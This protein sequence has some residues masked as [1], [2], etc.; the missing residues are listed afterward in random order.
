M[1]SV[2]RWCCGL[3]LL[4]LNMSLACAESEPP[5]PPVLEL[6][7]PSL[8]F[9][10]KVPRT[11]AETDRIQ[12]LALF[13]E[14]R[15]LAQ[16]NENE[17]ALRKFQRAFRYDQTSVTTLR[18]LLP[19]AFTLNRNSEAV[20]Y[21]AKFASLD[22]SDPTLLLRLAVV[23]TEQGEWKKALALYEKAI[24]AEKPDTKTAAGIMLRMEMGR[25]Y[26]LNDEPSKATASFAQVLAALSAPK[27]YQLSDRQ[28]NA[29]RGEKGNGLELMLTVFIET[30]DW[31]AAE[32]TLKE[33]PNWNNNPAVIHYLTATLL[34]AQAK[35][36]VALT[37]LEEYFTAR[38]TSRN[39]A[40]YELLRDI[41][42]ALKREAEL[43]TTLEE[44]AKAQPGNTTL[45]YALA[46]EYRRTGQYK[47]AIKLY[48]QA[49]DKQASREAYRGLVQSLLASEKH[50]DLLQTLGQIVS[51]TGTID[52]LLDADDD[53]KQAISLLA[54][55]KLNEKL[56]ALGLENYDGENIDHAAPLR[57]LGIIALNDKNWSAAEKLI[58]RSITAKPADKAELLLF[59]GIKLLI[60]EQTDA[61]VKVFQRGVDEKVLPESNPA[62]HFYLS[63]ALAFAKKY[64]DALAAAKIAQSKQPRSARFAAR[65]PWILSFAKRY[66]EAEKAYRELLTKYDPQY[67]SDEV[68]DVLREARLALSN[69][70]VLKK[71][72]P[73]A[74]EWIEAVLDEFP[75]DIHALNDLGYLWADQNKRLQRALVMIETALK[76]EPENKA[77]L[78]SHGWILYR[79]GRYEEALQSQLKAAEEKPDTK[80]PV[81]GVVLDHLAEIYAKLGQPTKAIETWQR[82]V[83]SLEKSDEQGKIDSVR[84]KLKAAT[85]QP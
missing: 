32:A 66:E 40:P 39:Y 29:L 21:A 38:E 72:L 68:R 17:A 85:T 37:E 8:P 15:V 28:L 12:A 19:L 54:D 7:D 14:G 73:L 41:L 9:Q 33:L 59:W 55:P 52:V 42:V 47:P 80:E 84:Q 13:A 11:E 65:I 6:D 62:F 53:D 74:E 20:R 46:E 22:A 75:D 48:R 30:K 67:D 78:D 18:E 10:P 36:S 60:G 49:L 23:L 16:R 56:F 61:A 79:V 34:H 77:Y 24:A 45:S 57:A 50:T 58:E 2:L 25:L 44:Q 71:D 35:H 43:I 70:A 82:A 1:L 3:L 64:D 31:P 4:V 5:R 76:A 83:Q 63:S 26:F 51:K 81:D 69:L 27:E